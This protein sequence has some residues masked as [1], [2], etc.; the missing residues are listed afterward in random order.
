MRNNV[1]TSGKSHKVLILRK[2]NNCKKE[3]KIKTKEIMLLSPLKGITDTTRQD[4]MNDDNFF[5]LVIE[6]Q[7]LK[8][9]SMTLV[10]YGL[11]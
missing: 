9:V 10:L 1:K 8:V 11:S 5:Q 3:E 2:S 4:E 7:K 6:S